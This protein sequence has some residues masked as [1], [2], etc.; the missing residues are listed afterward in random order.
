VTV[1]DGGQFEVGNLAATTIKSKTSVNVDSQLPN[2]INIVNTGEFPNL[3]FSYGNDEWVSDSGR[4][5]V[6][7]ADNKLSLLGF[8]STTV[9]MD[10]GF[11][12]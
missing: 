12:C 11:N 9:D 3:S 4:C 2:A 5:K 8:G 10:C 6:G 7:G 1:Y